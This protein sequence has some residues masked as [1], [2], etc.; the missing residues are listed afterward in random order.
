MFLIQSCIIKYYKLILP[1]IILLYSMP[2]AFFFWSVDSPV[3]N[4][5]YSKQIYHQHTPKISLE[6][7]VILDKGVLKSDLEIVLE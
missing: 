3:T 1:Y 6:F 4:S 2:L 7:N 5:M